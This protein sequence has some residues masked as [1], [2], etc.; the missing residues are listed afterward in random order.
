MRDLYKNNSVSHFGQVKTSSRCGRGGGEVVSGEGWGK[1]IKGCEHGNN[2]AA[3][4]AQ[5]STSS[6]WGNYVRRRAN[7]SVCELSFPVCSLA[8]WG[9]FF[10]VRVGMVCLCPKRRTP[11][12]LEHGIHHILLYENKK[13]NIPERKK[14]EWGRELVKCSLS[15]RKWR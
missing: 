1:K 10:S 4:E 12:A 8:R 3:D 7:L 15:Y 9:V 13:K 14:E 11:H 5:R 6:T 2:C